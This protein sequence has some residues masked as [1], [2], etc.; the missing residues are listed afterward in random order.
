MTNEAEAAFKQSVQL[1]PTSPEGNFR[2]AQLYTE[3]GRY[4][5]AI[6]VITELQKLDP[7]NDKISLAIEQMRKL[8]RQAEKK[9]TQ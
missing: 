4:D 3:N 5:D 1:C 2:L 9:Q 6:A 8:K 7:L